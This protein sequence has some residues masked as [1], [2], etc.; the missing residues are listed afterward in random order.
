MTSKTQRDRRLDRVESQLTDAVETADGDVWTVEWRDA[1]PAERPEGMVV[2]LENKTIYYDAWAA[3]RE[4]LA[5]LDGTDGDITAFLAGY[6]AGK[7]VL[8]ARWLLDQ[9]VSHG[10]SHFLALGVTYSEART[11]TYRALFEQLP[12]E[13]T[14]IVTSSFNGPEESPIVAD[15]NRSTHKLTLVNDTRITLGSADKWS[16]HAG[17]EFGAIWAD[18]PSHYAVDLHDLLEMMGSRLRGEDGAQTQ[19]W[20]LTGNGFNDAWEVLEKRETA[21]GDDLGHAIEVIRADTREN[22]YLSE[23]ETDSF[24]R[25]YGDTAR[26]EQALA[27]GFAAAQGLVYSDFTRETHVLD[28]SDPEGVV[29]GSDTFRIYGY[30]AGWADP[31]ALLEVGKTDYGQLV[32]LSEFYRS[33]T[34]VEDVVRFLEETEKPT[35]TI[36]AEH[37]PADIQKF[38]RAGWP[39]KEANKSLD[40]GISEVRKRLE[41][42]ADGRPGLLVSSACQNLIRELLGYKEEQVGT[43][44]AEDHAA[45]ALRYAVMGFETDP[46]STGPAFQTLEMGNTPVDITGDDT[47]A[48][49]TNDNGEPRHV[50]TGVADAIDSGTSPWWS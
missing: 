10:D 42:D 19:L 35:G 39:A 33:E 31:R 23:G 22:P 44:A 46:P 14:H 49:E 34:H 47:A 7:T 12:G 36:Y 11:S 18:E 25:Q 32:V 50:D 8:G 43:A 20:T 30:D 1:A 45:D 5:E 41:T 17:D 3:Q 28:S 21:D 24:E 16:R 6:G 48:V 40:A 2:D 9:A 15:Y 38:D 27:G 13:R 29:D 4:T 37:E 26:E